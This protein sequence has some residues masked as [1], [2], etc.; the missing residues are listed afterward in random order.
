MILTLAFQRKVTMCWDEILHLRLAISLLLFN[1]A[2][3]F[4]H[5]IVPVQFLHVQN[6][7]LMRTNEI[8]LTFAL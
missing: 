8:Q 2:T 6:A 3:V 4:T 7:K 1:K 5:Q